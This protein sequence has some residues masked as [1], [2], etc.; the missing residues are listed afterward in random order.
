MHT[1]SLELGRLAEEAGVKALIP[2]H[3][4]GEVEF[5]LKEIEEEVRQNYRGRL[6]IPKDLERYSL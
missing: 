2:C 3:F 5:S 6:L 1:N 4:F